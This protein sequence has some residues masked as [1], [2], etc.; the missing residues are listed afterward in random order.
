M[1]IKLPWLAF[2]IEK[3]LLQFLLNPLLSFLKEAKDVK[4]WTPLMMAAY[5]DF[6]TVLQLLLDRRAKIDA[7]EHIGDT[8][9]ILAA[10]QGSALSVRELLRR[11][12]NKNHMNNNGH[13][14]LDK[15]RNNHHDLVIRILIQEDFETDKLN[16]PVTSFQLFNFP[17][18][19]S[20][21]A[22]KL[23]EFN[24]ATDPELQLA[25]PMIH[26]LVQLGDNNFNGNKVQFC[27]WLHNCPK[28]TIN[29]LMW[30]VFKGVPSCKTMRSEDTSG[31]TKM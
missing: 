29:E 21:I 3:K 30:F 14:A 5:F 10:Q 16:F 1:D 28:E 4:G 23:K 26:R 18:N 13:T 20:K 2:F 24:E 12:A 6:L 9:L 17:P 25:A 27:F 7:T 19:C 11:G 8:A 22:A 15:A 31:F